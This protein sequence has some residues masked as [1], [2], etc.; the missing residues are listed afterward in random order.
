MRTNSK[1]LWAKLLSLAGWLAMASVAWAQP[2]PYLGFVYPAGGQQGTTF[3]IRLGGQ[4]WDDL[5]AVAVT[6]KGVTARITE[7]YRRM[8]NMEMQLI[9]E[10]ASVLRRKTLSDSSRKT[11]TQMDKEVMM[12]D[13]A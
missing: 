12:T 11:L 2:R 10:Q 4:G 5:S 8:D 3:Q 1:L 7:N 6:G 13:A 9:N